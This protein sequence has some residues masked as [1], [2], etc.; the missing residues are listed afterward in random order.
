MADCD[1]GEILRRNRSHRGSVPALIT[2]RFFSSFLACSR[3]RIG[4]L[5]RNLHIDYQITSTVPVCPIFIRPDQCG[6]LL[7]LTRFP[8]SAPGDADRG[9]RASALVLAQMPET[10]AAP[11]SRS[12]RLCTRES[13]PICRAD[14]RHINV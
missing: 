2:V 3:L 12:N 6:V 4:D 11:L 5:A 10:P 9:D 1:G 7:Q 14:A 13:A 8:I